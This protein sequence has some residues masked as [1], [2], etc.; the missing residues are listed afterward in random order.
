MHRLVGGVHHG[1]RVDHGH[2]RGVHGRGWRALGAAARGAGDRR[3]SVV[4]AHVW[5]PTPL[6]RRAVEPVGN[7][8]G[9]TEV[10][11]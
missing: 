6:V 8:G 4:R 9:R 7:H 3:V 11:M 5:G 1:R 10:E 2:H